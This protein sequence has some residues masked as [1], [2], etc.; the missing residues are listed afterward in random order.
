MR[1][2]DLKDVGQVFMKRGLFMYLHIPIPLGLRVTM[3]LFSS[4]LQ[5]SSN[6]QQNGNI[7]L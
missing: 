6:C 1:Q 7:Q 4:L 2:D 5:F 3:S